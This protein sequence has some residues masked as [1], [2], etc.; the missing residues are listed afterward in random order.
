MEANIARL[1]ALLDRYESEVVCPLLT[2]RGYCGQ[3]NIN[4]VF[5]KLK[6]DLGLSEIE[7]SREGKNVQIYR[8][9]DD[10]FIK[11]LC[12]CD[13]PCGPS[14]CSTLKT[15]LSCDGHHALIVSPRNDL[16]IDENTDYVIDFTYKQ[17]LYGSEHNPTIPEEEKENKPANIRTLESLPG[18]LF[19][20][21]KDYINYGTTSVWRKNITNPCKNIVNF[22]IKYMTE[23]DYYNKYLTYKSKYLALKEKLKV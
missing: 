11:R 6:T 22:N 8:L 1:T 17:M 4:T 21:Y 23:T 3:I 14:N 16:T 12:V 15:K 10:T 5:D 20:K 19:M 18:Y 9:D 13:S 2:R 7:L